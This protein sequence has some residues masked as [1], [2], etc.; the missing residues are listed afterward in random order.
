MS[1]SVGSEQSLAS[2]ERAL[3]DKVWQSVERE[4]ISVLDA[5]LSELVSEEFDSARKY[6]KKTTVLRL[7]STTHAL[8]IKSMAVSSRKKVL[9]QSLDC[10]AETD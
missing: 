5:R 8:A 4:A 2:D 1:A 3:V 10:Y 7:Y 9:S 6:L